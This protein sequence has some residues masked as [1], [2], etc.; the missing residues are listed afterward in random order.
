MSAVGVDGCCTTV[1]SIVHGTQTKGHDATSLGRYL[2]NL[3][4][5]P[6]EFPR[7]VYAVFVSDRTVPA[8][9]I[10]LP[11]IDDSR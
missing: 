1:R 4:R 10:G 9:L 7:L 2:T 5:L 6:R 3:E 8:Y 11:H